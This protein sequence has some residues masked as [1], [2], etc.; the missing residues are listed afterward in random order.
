MEG[1][2][3]LGTCRGGSQ[4][5]A[6]WFASKPQKDPGSKST[7]SR[8][9]GVRCGE[10]KGGLGCEPAE[11]AARL[12]G[13]HPSRRLSDNPSFTST[14]EGKYIFFGNYK[15]I[16]LNPAKSS[17]EDED[18]IKTFSNML[19]LKKFPPIYNT[20]CAPSKWE[21]RPTKR[22]MRA[23]GN[24]GANVGGRSP[25][26]PGGK[27]GKAQGDGHSRAGRVGPRVSGERVG[28]EAG[29][30]LGAISDQGG[31][32]TERCWLV[33]GESYWS[34]KRKSKFKKGN[35]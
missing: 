27:E 32:H 18:R 17:V 14:K 4:G 20:G 23:L 29:D 7:K 9:G 8:D 13:L 16:I 19:S 34:Y 33:C 30:R 35:Y 10:E 25:D 2:E 15:P 21:S 6:S 31:N 3:N 26:T 28:V 22:E 24:R 11:W 5:K 12:T 1:D